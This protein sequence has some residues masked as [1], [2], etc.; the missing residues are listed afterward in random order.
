MSNKIVG[1]KKILMGNPLHLHSNLGA[2]KVGFPLTGILQQNN[3]F[4]VAP[5]LLSYFTASER[6]SLGEAMGP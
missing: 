6:N 5:K 3:A 4:Y 1:K 2:K